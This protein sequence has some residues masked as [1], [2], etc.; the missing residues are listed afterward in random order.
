MASTQS[1]SVL[2]ALLY[3]TACALEAPEPL[4][5]LI[6]SGEND[7]WHIQ[8][9]YSLSLARSHSIAT[10]VD[11]TRG[12]VVAQCSL[13]AD[14]LDVKLSPDGQHIAW[15]DR[16]SLHVVQAQTCEAKAYAWSRIWPS[17][18]PAPVRIE[19]ADSGHVVSHS[20][21]PVRVPIANPT[22]SALIGPSRKVPISSMDVAGEIAYCGDSSGAV[23]QCDRN[24][25]LLT[26]EKR[27]SSVL[28]VE[29]RLCA[30]TDQELRCGE[31]N[32]DTEALGWRY[33]KLYAVNNH[34]WVQDRAAVSQNEGARWFKVDMADGPQLHPQTEALSWPS[35][36]S[37]ITL[38]E[39]HLSNGTHAIPISTP[40]SLLKN[41][42]ILAWQSHQGVYVASKKQS[43]IQ[44]PED[45]AHLQF[46][47]EEPLCVQDNHLYT[48]SDPQQLFSFPSMGTLLSSGRRLAIGQRGQVS[49]LENEHRIDY[50]LDVRHRVSVMAL[51]TGQNGVLLG[52]HTGSVLRWDV[53][54]NKWQE[55][56]AYPD[57][58]VD[59]DASDAEIVVALSDEPFVILDASGTR[60][61]AEAA[62]AV[63]VNGKKIAVAARY[64]GLS[65]LNES[66]RCTAA[67]GVSQLEW[68]GDD[69]LAWG[70]LSSG[71]W[72]IGERC[73]RLTVQGERLLWFDT[74]QPVKATEL[75]R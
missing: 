15:L 37:W 12:R 8:D 71:V 47:G 18:P 75:G 58:V 63:A 27:I 5:Q 7:I 57:D 72:T 59:L 32:W 26:L 23:F 35:G 70:G 22:Q 45:C 69:T 30:L 33:P 46:L 11:W 4:N 54:Q 51:G 13:G 73:R 16:K 41:S 25:V 40:L 65:L 56:G 66:S 28:D 3:F 2:G 60:V 43:Y 42:A 29:G 1:S 31:K 61:G 6:L 24:E 68:I 52:T 48:L 39:S 64:G 19:W 17:A 34:L 20:T 50:P 9:G 49:I 10:V 38:S 53:A 62:S 36:D 44:R 67:L 74:Q 21:P 14:L 55:R